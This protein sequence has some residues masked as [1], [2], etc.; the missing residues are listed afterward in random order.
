MMSFNTR[1]TNI[2]PRQI[3]PD[4][5]VYSADG[6][7]LG[8]V[9]EVR[10]G[11]LVV[12]KGMLFQHEL[13]IPFSAITRVEPDS[14]HLQVT[15]DQVA[16]QGWD[17]MPRRDAGASARGMH[18]VDERE[19]ATDAR[20]VQLR[21]EE[22]QARKQAVEGGNVQIRKEVVSEQQTL[23]VPVRREEVVVERHPVDRAEGERMGAGEIGES[24]TIRVP[25]H[26]E[27][28]TVEKTPVVREE[29]QVGKRTIQDTERVSANV[30]REEAVIDHDEEV[31]VQHRQSG[32]PHPEERRHS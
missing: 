23:D 7:D 12:K 1:T 9:Q 18:A 30:R 16:N 20:T 27:R 29:I 3:Q 10:D 25:V 6:E 8:D 5:D 11:Y 14:V 24:E 28:V 32:V 22:L 13:Y 15:R 31:D 26:E 21:E 17:Q 2:D 4:Y 19:G